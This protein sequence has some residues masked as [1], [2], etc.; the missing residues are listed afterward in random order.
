MHGCQ[1]KPIMK[2]IINFVFIGLRVKK[3]KEDNKV[4]IDNHPVCFI[5]KANN[6]QKIASE[7]QSLKKTSKGFGF[8]PKVISYLK[9]G[10][11]EKCSSRSLNNFL[12]AHKIKGDIDF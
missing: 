12:Q 4:I 6:F 5:V 8:D 2:I 7:W 3:A 10:G 9:S 1:K 11:Q